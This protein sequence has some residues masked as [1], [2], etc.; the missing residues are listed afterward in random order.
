[1]LRGSTAGG[2]AYLTCLRMPN[3]ARLEGPDRP[4]DPASGSDAGL[5]VRLGAGLG[6]GLGTGFGVGLGV[7][8]GVH[9]HQPARQGAVVAVELHGRARLADDGDDAVEQRLGRHRLEQILVRA[10]ARRLHHPPAVAMSA[11]HDDRHPASGIRRVSAPC[12]RTG[13]RRSSAFPNRRSRGRARR[14]GSRRGPTCRRRRRRWSSPPSPSAWCAR[15]CA[16]SGRRP[17]PRP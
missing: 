11:Q 14:C 6:V 3:V 17:R 7:G 13:R 5:G 1:M 15:P 2:A 4:S 12:A 16:C 10:D 9:H 8:F